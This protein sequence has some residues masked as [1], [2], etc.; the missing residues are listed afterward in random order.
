MLKAYD[1]NTGKEIKKGD[2]ITDFR[3]DKHIFARASRAQT[4]NK[5]GKICTADNYEYYDRV[6]N[7]I[8]K[9]ITE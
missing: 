1:K 2:E 7:I 4:E 9:E 5:S 6:F 8:V 3:G